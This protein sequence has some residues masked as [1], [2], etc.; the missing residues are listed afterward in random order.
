MKADEKR[1]T[2]EGAELKNHLNDTTES[3]VLSMLTGRPQSRFDIARRLDIDEREFRRIVHRLR[4]AGYPIC[5]DS[6]GKGYWLG[7]DA[8]CRKTII[9]LRGRAYDLLR[10][11]DIMEAANLTLQGQIVMEDI[12]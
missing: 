8:E 1:T 5:T 2:H 3:K 4:A 11:A 10:T 7:T 6:S 9:Q 12:K